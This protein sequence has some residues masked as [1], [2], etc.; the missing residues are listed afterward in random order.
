LFCFDLV[1]LCWVG[2]IIIYFIEFLIYLFFF[3]FFFFFFFLIGLSPYFL[4]SFFPHS[5]SPFLSFFSFS[6]LLFFII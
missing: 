6:L 4:L 1:L 2:I 3:F 5:P